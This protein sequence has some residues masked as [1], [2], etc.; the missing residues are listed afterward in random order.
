MRVQL[1]VLLLF[2]A[3]SMLYSN[4]ADAQFFK[5]LFGKKTKK[6]RSETVKDGNSTNGNVTKSPKS[7]V[8]V[9]H[10]SYLKDAYQVDVLLPL[11]LD[12]SFDNDDKLIYEKALPGKLVPSL[13]FYEGV[14]I[15]IDTLRHYGYN[16]K[17]RIHDITRNH[18]TPEMLIRT[19]VLDES[20]LII[21]AL[22]SDDI[23][24]LA[25]FAKEHEVN[26]ISALSPSDA[27]VH[28][29][30]YFILLQPTLEE[31]CSWLSNKIYRKYGSSIKPILL[32]RESNEL[33]KR[34]YD[35]IKKKNTFVFNQ[36]N[37]NGGLKSNQI[38]PYLRPD[39]KNIVVMPILSPK[40]A[41]E[42]IKQLYSWY[43]DYRFEVW[44]MPSWKNMPSLK[45]PDA[46]PNA[47]VYFSYPFYFDGSTGYGRALSNNY[48]EKYAN[49][50]PSELVYRGYETMMWSVHLLHRYG[51]VFNNNVNGG[52]APFTR[53][54]VEKLRINNRIQYLH[55]THLYLYRYQSS[56]F[57][58]EN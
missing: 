50:H 25:D 49:D 3:S 6:E 21:G 47:V 31:H 45:E 7:E 1:R 58:I 57:M 9:Y 36:V 22:N 15:A 35:N 41:G 52:L 51:K 26:F 46:Y 56:S 28:N 38:A 5:K 2:L 4:T 27:G 40:S 11:Y 20:D 33:D 42:I 29:N 43:P 23:P 44:G 30:P 13:C 48:L 39:V 14:D 24:E 54:K 19:G 53:Y 34:A 32:Y 37:C 12:E 8:F 55:N 18:K 17:V 16:V 10:K